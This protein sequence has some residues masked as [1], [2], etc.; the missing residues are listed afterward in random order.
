MAYKQ[1]SSTQLNVWDIGCPNSRTLAGATDQISSGQYFDA[2][3]SF[4]NQSLKSTTPNETGGPYYFWAET[5]PYANDNAGQNNAYVL[6][7]TDGNC[8]CEKQIYVMANTNT[9]NYL[10][11]QKD[12]NL[13]LFNADGLS[14]LFQTGTSTDTNPFLVMQNDG[15]LVEYGDNNGTWQALWQSA[16]NWASTNSGLLYGDQLNEGYYLS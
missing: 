5:I 4:T 16:T 7:N 6:Q 9:P 10:V 13:V 14:P 1:I 15:N 2:D 12:G 8:S 3:G 11:L